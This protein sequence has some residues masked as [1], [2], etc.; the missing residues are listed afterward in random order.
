MDINEAIQTIDHAAHQDDR[1]MF[2]ALLLIGLITIYFL[3][4]YFMKQIAELQQ[5]IAAVRTEFESH[6]KTANADM[7]AALTKST[8][9]IAH[10]SAILEQIQKKLGA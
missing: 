2:V 10:N 9:V 8:E 6:L 4:R 5:E 3:A 7:V 1:W